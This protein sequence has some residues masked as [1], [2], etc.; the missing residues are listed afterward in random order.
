LLGALVHELL[1]IVSDGNMY[2]CLTISGKTKHAYFKP[3]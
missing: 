2:L 3:V 1:E